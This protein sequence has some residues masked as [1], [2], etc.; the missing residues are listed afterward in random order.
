MLLGIFFK[1][2]SCTTQNSCSIATPV[3][4]NYHRLIFIIPV[5]DLVSPKRNR[6][7]EVYGEKPSKESLLSTRRDNVDE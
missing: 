1:F 6:S 7:V 4:V 3:L 5:V 2:R